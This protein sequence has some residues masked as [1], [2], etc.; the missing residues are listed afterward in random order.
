MSEVIKFLKTR[1]VLS[2]SRAFPFD[3]GI[4][5]FVPEFTVRFIKDLK[6][7]NT[8]LFQEE[9]LSTMMQSYCMSSAGMTSAGS[10]TLNGNPHSTHDNTQKV[11]YDLQDENDTSFKFDETR[12][13]LYFLLPPHSRVLIP[14]GIHVRMAS[15]GRALIAANKSGVATKHGLIF[16]AEVVDYTYTGEVHIGIINTSTKIVR[17]YEN[18]KLIQFLETPIYCNP[19]EVVEEFKTPADNMYTFYEGLESDRGDAGFGSTD[20][21]DKK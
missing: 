20:K 21:K 9:T 2:P 11:S 10:L 17:I 3:A 18:M 1:K 19:I 6:E 7:K 12:G 14:S 8:E 13:E 5:F 16:S 15:K 4:D